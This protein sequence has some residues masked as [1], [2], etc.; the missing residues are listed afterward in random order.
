MILLDCNM[1]VMNGYE[2]AK[3][4][5]DMRADG[6]IGDIPVIALTAN[7]QW[8]DPEKCFEAGMDGYIAKSLWLPKWKPRLQR[9][10]C[11]W[12]PLSIVAPHNDD[13][14]GEV[15][16]PV[17]VTKT[18]ELVGRKF[19]ALIEVF[20]SDAKQHIENLKHLAQNKAPAEEAVLHAYAL[21]FSSRQVGA[22]QMA[23]IAE[24]IMRRSSVLSKKNE[25]CSIFLAEEL[26]DME[27][28]YERTRVSLS[29]SIAAS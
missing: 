1:P 14:G 10:I 18:K 13:G 17:A 12:L 29:D 26:P 16:N 28:A 20:L 3:K 11:Q 7:Q 2:A 25:D 5:A 19:R 24:K 6:R 23:R 4:I 27:R 22:L 9:M 15:V 8:G 21:T